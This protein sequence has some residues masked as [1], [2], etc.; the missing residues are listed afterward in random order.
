[1]PIQLA[2]NFFDSDAPETKAAADSDRLH[3]LRFLEE[4]PK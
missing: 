3:N 2:F 1:M 4:S